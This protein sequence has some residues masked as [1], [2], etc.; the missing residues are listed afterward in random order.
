MNSQARYVPVAR[1]V[2]GTGDPHWL[3]QELAGHLERLLGT[4]WHTIGNVE[5]LAGV[6]DAAKVGWYL[7]WFQC[8]VVGN[9]FVGYLGNCSAKAYEIQ[10]VR[11]ALREVGA[12]RLAHLF[13]SGIVLCKKYEAEFWREEAAATLFSGLQVEGPWKDLSDLDDE[14]V[15][16]ADKFLDQAVDRYLHAKAD[17]I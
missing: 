5:G 7:W 10:R 2:F 14:V 9:G 11:E 3:M 8:E 6:P 15:H 4:S 16:L 12:E 1:D 13:D 17:E